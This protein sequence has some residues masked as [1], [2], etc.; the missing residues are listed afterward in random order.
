M[1]LHLCFGLLDLWG[2]QI[3]CNFLGL[4]STKQKRPRMV[5][6]NVQDYMNDS[7][8][9]YTAAGVNVGYELMRILCS[10]F[11]SSSY[12]SFGLA[13]VLLQSLCLKQQFKPRF[14]LSDM[15]KFFT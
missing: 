12:Y 10:R 7:R 15:D 14:C 11:L 5:Y 2:T 4:L 3:T 8:E 9:F 6:V 1:C 13:V